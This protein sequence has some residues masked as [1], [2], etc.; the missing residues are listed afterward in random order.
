MIIFSIEN[1]VDGCQFLNNTATGRTIGSGA[2]LFLRTFSEADILTLTNSRFIGNV[3]TDD[4]FN[5]G[6]ALAATLIETVIVRNCSFIENQIISTLAKGQNGMFTD[7]MLTSFYRSCF[8]S[9]RN[10]LR[11]F[12]L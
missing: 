11:S 9:K 12:Q 6:T 2:A 4:V 10:F 7:I 1:V 3:I 8:Y 5:E